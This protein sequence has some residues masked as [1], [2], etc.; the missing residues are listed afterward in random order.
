MTDLQKDQAIYQALCEIAD[1]YFN[2]AIECNKM[3][4][5]FMAEKNIVTPKEITELPQYRSAVGGYENVHN[6]P[7]YEE[8]EIIVDTFKCHFDGENVFR[9]MQHFKSLAKAK[10]EHCFTYEEVIPNDFI[11][12]VEITFDNPANAKN[13]VNHA[14]HDESLKPILEHILLEINTL[15]GDINFIATDG[16]TL[17]VISNDIKSAKKQPKD[18]GHLIQ[19][20]FTKADW[21]RICDYAR[22]SKSRVTFEM[23]RRRKVVNKDTKSLV[24]EK[25]DTMCA[26][27]GD[28]KV[29]SIVMR[30]SYPTWR[31]VVQNNT[32]KHFAIHPDDVKVAQSFIQGIKVPGSEK[33]SKNIFVSFYHGSDIAYFDFFDRG[34]EVSKTVTFRL[35][36]PA[37]ITIGTNYNIKRLQRV[38]FTG[39][40]IEESTR[41]SLLDSEDTDLMLIM[42][43][44]SDGG[45]VFNAKEREN[46]A[47]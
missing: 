33:D 37:T 27:L 3:F 13:L 19:A 46:V 32:N 1:K 2:K 17:A 21:K 47:A 34:N 35:A 39:F 10:G 7:F 11:G 23:Y 31:S 41:P 43:M 29:R 8:E 26:I 40:N 36:E 12:T 22:K 6:T 44:L 18:E 9:I 5:K 16:K 15:S 28:V 42:P 38:K 24:E 4:R 14:E 30:C 45:Y 25:Q 20:L